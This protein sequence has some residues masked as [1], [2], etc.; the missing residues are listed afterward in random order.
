M[1]QNSPDLDRFEPPEYRLARLNRQ[2]REMMHTTLRPHGLK[3]VEWRVL[4]C[5]MP[6][7]QALTIAD[8]AELAV[9]ERTVTSRLIERM[10]A[11]GLVTKT[12]LANDRR[13]AQ[14]T[15]TDA[16]RRAYAGADADARAARQ[17]LFWGLTDTDISALLDLLDRMER[18]TALPLSAPTSR[19]G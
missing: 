16:G 7:G 13:F 2:I 11:R 10:V 19:A 5:L 14:I 12:A 17:R 3:L 4:Q 9:I 1:T 6:E 8:L 15:A 18:N